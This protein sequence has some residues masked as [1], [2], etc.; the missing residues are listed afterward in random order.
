MTETL[1]IR[2]P[3]ALLRELK[4]KT[5][6]AKTNPSAVLRQAATNYVRQFKPEINPMQNHILA[7]AGTWDGDI[8]GVELLKRTRP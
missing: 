6:L 2:L 8:S 3:A 4:A 5:K 7:R 1:T